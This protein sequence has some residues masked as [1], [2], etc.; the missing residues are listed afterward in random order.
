MLLSKAIDLTDT[1]TASVTAHLPGPLATPVTLAVATVTWVPRRLV[2]AVHEV[3]Q[4]ATDAARAAEGS[5]AAHTSEPA[6]AEEP[7]P[8]GQPTESTEPAVVLTLDR[9]AEHL[10]PPV[11]VVGEALA[12]EAAEQPPL[13]EDEDH[14]EVEE[15]VV[16]S[17]SSDDA[18]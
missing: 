7:A 5:G 3:A 15:Q 17:S 14:V 11:D 12:A 9:P 1:V 16:Y 10:E 4:D 13:H 6:P 18:R 8:A 2:G